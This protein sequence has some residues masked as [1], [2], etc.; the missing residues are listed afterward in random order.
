MGRAGGRRGGGP[1]LRQAVIVAGGRGSR[2]GA[3]AAETPKPLLEVGG[4]PFVEHLLFELGRFGI[5]DVLLLVGP[6]RKAFRRALAPLRRGDMKLVLVP[7]PAPAGTAGALWH[8]RKRLAK[9]FLLLNGDSIFDGNLLRLAAEAGNAAGAVAALEVPDTARYGRIECAGTRIAA[10]REKGARGAGLVNAGAYVF[11]RARLLA[12]IAKPPCSLERDVLPA[13]AA[14]RA[15]RAAI[16][17]GRFIDIGLPD[18]LAAARGLFPAWHRRPAAFIELSALAAVEGAAAVPR[19]RKGAREAIRRLNDA[20]YYTLVLAPGAAQGAALRRRLNAALSKQAAHIDALYAAR[21]K[22]A[23]ETLLATARGAW[24]LAEEGSFL[25][26]GAPHIVA[27]SEPY[28]AVFRAAGAG[29]LDA[30]V[31]AALHAS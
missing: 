28:L 2:L 18:S 25:V 15:L 31:A 27:Q 11:D 16:Y 8:A 23:F 20:G 6:Y 10:F 22:S 4:R 26:T 5:E 3:L 30:L 14:A 21:A 12:R 24:P 29:N 17:K 1:L 9:R 13:L 7:E 19:W